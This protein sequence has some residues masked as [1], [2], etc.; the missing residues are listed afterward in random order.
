MTSLVKQDEQLKDLAIND[1]SK[2]NVE[3][4]LYSATLFNKASEKEN[5]YKK[6]TELF[7]GDFRAFNNLGGMALQAGNISQ[8]KSNLD[9]AYSL[10]K[11]CRSK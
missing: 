5:I 10:S 11:K 6:A 1:P 9:K 2:L 4:L 7:P 8:A 3:E